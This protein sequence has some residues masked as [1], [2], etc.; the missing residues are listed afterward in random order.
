MEVVFIIFKILKIVLVSTF[1]LFQPFSSEFV[2]HGVR[3]FLIFIIVGSTGLVLQMLQSMFYSFTAIQVIFQLGCLPWRSSSRFGK[4]GK[5]F[6]ALLDQSYRCYKACFIN[7]HLFRSS[8][9]VVV[10]HGGRLPDFH[11]IVLGSTEL[12]L[13][14]L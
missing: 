8:S 13:Q 10:F 5:L 3:L 12:V 9:S 6:Q 11:K 7:F 2:F 1:Q 4:F 14:M